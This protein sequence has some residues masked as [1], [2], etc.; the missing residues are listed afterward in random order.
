MD[1]QAIS[2]K[3]FMATLKRLRWYFVLPFLL[4]LVSAAALAFSLPPV[5]RSTGTIL[6]E[7]QGLPTDLVR[8]TISSAV[9]ERI[10]VI[11][12]R[13]MSAPNLISIMDK[14]GL[15]PDIRKGAD[16][17]AA[18]L[19]MKNSV[20]L[21]TQTAEVIDP[22]T[23]RPMAVTIS[24]SISFD[25]DSPKVS[26]GVATDLV[27]L[28]L[29][30]NQRERKQVTQEASRFL[31][32]ESNRLAA[33][34]S[35]LEGRLATFKTESGESLPEMMGANLDAVQRAN[36]RLRDIDQSINGL[37][38]SSILLEGELA[39]TSPYQAATSVGPTGERVLPPAEQ[40]KFLESQAIAL[41]ARYSPAHPDRINVERELKALRAA[42]K[43]GTIAA[44]ASDPDNPAYIQLRARLIAND[45]EI[46]A[47]KQSRAQLQEQLTDYQR[48][49][50]Q[51]P[52]VEKQYLALARDH[53]SALDR[54]REVRSK[55]MQAKMAESLETESKG[56]R[57]S[58]ISP[59]AFSDVP[60]KPN[61]PALL[62]L[63][64]ILAI[65]SGFGSVALRQAFD[66]AVYGARA[67]TRITGAAPLA[68]IPFIE[69][70]HDRRQSRDRRVRTLAFVALVGVAGLLAYF[71]LVQ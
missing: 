2:L 20:K 3:S 44:S 58:L 15:Y 52:A 13:V 1:D 17:S 59:P 10:A 55:L 62:F 65:G 53:Q 67:L 41:S 28:F 60:V 4:V 35:E 42:L 27:N 14:Y 34:I 26:Q 5:Y 22:R 19:L 68:V 11:R 71:V 61:R 29:A 43:N 63:G 40:L 46:K 70:V 56:E 12:Q 33:E 69:T 24:F 18:L 21:E 45:T 32:D 7:Q 36:D 54:Y 16:N 66:H 9:D 37:T 23:A 25:S 6:I 64:V 49:I 50:A 57:F 47:L 51:S 30:E 39:R 8:S 38:E 31:E 48:R